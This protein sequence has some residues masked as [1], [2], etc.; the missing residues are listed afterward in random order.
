MTV[1][2][3]V[4]AK[5][6]AAKSA[7]RILATASTQTKNHALEE[8]ARA[9]QSRADIILEANKLD[10]EAGREK[11]LSNALWT[12]SSLRKTGLLKARRP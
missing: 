2:D 11:G 12:G 1:K 3:N 4:E 8:M 6:R 5:G 7:S 9:L 10:M